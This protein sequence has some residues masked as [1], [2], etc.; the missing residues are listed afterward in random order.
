MASDLNGIRAS[1]ERSGGRDRNRGRGRGSYVNYYDD[2]GMSTTEEGYES[3]KASEEEYA[4]AVATDQ[5]NI[6]AGYDSMSDIDRVSYDSLYDDAW[7]TFEKEQNFIPVRVMDGDT[8]ESTYYLPSDTASSLS[9]KL[10]EAYHTTLTDGWLN[11]DVDAKA[12]GGKRGQEVHDA[13]RGTVDQVKDAFDASVMGDITAAVS[14]TNSAIDAAYGNL[15]MSQDQLNT[16]MGVHDT[17]ADKYKTDYSDRLSKIEASIMG[18]NSFG[19]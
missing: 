11:I 13:V 16:A 19:K 9:S 8:V 3:W 7:S 14:T 10:S 1:H 4:N 15:D 6:T 12:G 18:V 17:Q 5:G 2:L